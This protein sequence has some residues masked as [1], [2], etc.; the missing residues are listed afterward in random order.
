MMRPHG[1]H[2]LGNS[3]GAMARL[4]TVRGVEEQEAQEDSA[5][6]SGFRLFTTPT[7]K[8]LMTIRMKSLL[9]RILTNESVSK[10]C[11]DGLPGLQ[12]QLLP[13]RG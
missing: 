13:V 9:I 2:T 1:M 6:Q 7:P 3:K 4:E 10:R 8:T 11:V 12:R 5:H